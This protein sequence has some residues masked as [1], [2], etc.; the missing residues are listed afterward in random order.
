[1]HVPE[2]ILVYHPLRRLQ[3]PLRDLVLQ[4]QLASL[5]EERYLSVEV[6]GAVKRVPVHHRFQPVDAFL[7]FSKVVHVDPH[8]RL[9]R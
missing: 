6:R 7:Q 5:G 3:P 9:R 8:V 2:V 1:M 4:R